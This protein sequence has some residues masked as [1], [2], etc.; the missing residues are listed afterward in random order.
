M[1]GLLWVVLFTAFSVVGARGAGARNPETVFHADFEGKEALRDWQGASEGVRP[2]TGRGGTKGVLIE[3][4]ESAGAGSTMIHLSLPLDKVRGGRLKCEA[5]IR[6]DGVVKPPNVWNG[7]K[8]MLHVVS[9]EGQQWVQQNSIYGT[10]D[11]K[12]VRF[13]T[14]IPADAS[15]VTLLLGL[16]ETT[17]TV[18]FDDVAISSMVRKTGL[19]AKTAYKGHN[20]PRL[21]GAMIGVVNANDLRTLG[22]E[23]KANHVRWQLTWDGFPKSPADTAELPAY[24]AWLESQLKRLDSLLPV[25]KAAGL[26]VL[27]DMHTPPGGR[28]EAAVCRLFEEKR[29]QEKFLEVWDTIARRYNGNKTVWGYDLVNE[30]VEGTMPDGLLDWHDLAAAAAKRVRAIDRNHAIIVEPAPW[31]SPSSIDLFE[32][33]DIPGVVYSVH[34]YEPHQLTHQGVDVQV[35]S[36]INYPGEIDGRMWDKER[37]RKVLQP[38]VDFQKDYNAHIYI[39]EFSIIRWAPGDSAYNYLRDCIDIFEENGWDWAYHAYREWDGWSVEHGS[40]RNDRA[41]S[42]TETAREKLLRSWYAHDKKP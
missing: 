15:E 5:W 33:I 18:R 39:G 13:M 11:W 31:A 7:V 2:D 17:G 23:W 19:R 35:K 6:A 9:P 27:V 16:E 3:R 4:P 22:N 38:V 40:D 10:F 42:K 24:D 26:L 14:R 28:D 37:L 41:R 29:Y 32:P 30:P 21:R 36:P 34:M 1:R 8:F 20:L 12:P 25:C